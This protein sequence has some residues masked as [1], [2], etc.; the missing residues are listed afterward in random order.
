[1]RTETESEI[2]IEYAS[3]GMRYL[4]GGRCLKSISGVIEGLSHYLLIFRILVMA[5]DHYSFKF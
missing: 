4:G 1:M 5:D 3:F 2:L